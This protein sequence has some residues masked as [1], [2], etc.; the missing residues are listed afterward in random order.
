M[1]PLPLV[2]L[3]SSPT[4]EERHTEIDLGTSSLCCQNCSRERI[5]GILDGF[6]V[7]INN[8]PQAYRKGTISVNSYDANGFR[9]SFVHLLLTGQSVYHLH[10]HVLGGTQMKWPPG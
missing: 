7:V 3:R 1:I 5:E 2:A 6:R 8:G 9:M 10:L 4:A